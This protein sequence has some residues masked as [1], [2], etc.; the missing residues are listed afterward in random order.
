M[1]PQPS[2]RQSLATERRHRPGASTSLSSSIPPL[3]AL[4]IYRPAFLSRFAWLASAHG[5]TRHS[6]VLIS[7]KDDDLETQTWTRSRQ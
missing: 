2:W 3:R 1:L 5:H 4:Y 7:S 6:R